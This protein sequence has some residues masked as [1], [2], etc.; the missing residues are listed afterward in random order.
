[1]ELGSGEAVR[2]QFIAALP[3]PNQEDPCFTSS[4]GIHV[5]LQ[6]C[7]GVVHNCIN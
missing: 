3:F 4:I 5:R 6:Y 2:E 7:V 1:M